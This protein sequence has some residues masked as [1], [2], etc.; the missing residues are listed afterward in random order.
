M[1]FISRRGAIAGVMVG[2]VGGVLTFIVWSSR[3]PLDPEQTLNRAIALLADRRLIEAEPLL[4][5]YLR[6][7]PDGVN[8]HLLLAQ[9][10]LEKSALTDPPDAAQSRRALGHLARIPIAAQM[11]PGEATRTETVDMARERSLASLVKLNEGKARSNLAQPA[12]AEVAWSAVLR[13]TPEVAEAG[14]LLLDLYIHQ[15]REAEA[16][17]LGLRLAEAEPDV[18]KRLE[19]LLTLAWFDA[20]QVAPQRVIRRFEPAVRR[21]PDDRHAAIALGLALVR[22]HREVEG[23][24]ILRHTVARAPDDPNALCALL[25][26]L[27]ESQQSDALMESVARI[28]AAWAVTEPFS[29]HI[30]LAALARRDW[31]AATTAL[32]RASEAE[33]HRI[34]LAYQLARALRLGGQEAEAD[35]LAVRTTRLRQSRDELLEIYRRLLGHPARELREVRDVL[36]FAGGAPAA[37]QALVAQNDP[38]PLRRF[39][40][41]CE[42]LGFPDQAR[43]WRRALTELYPWAG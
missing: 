1:R 41:L 42:D 29:E 17:R 13:L 3:A 19:W 39:A 7:Y 36:K 31:P 5:D 38:A 4:D 12:A 32:R 40:E 10:A 20:A 35:R 9:L 11:I 27:S 22:D 14:W 30:G 28:P 24:E 25:T 21:R 34:E 15:G 23:L 43:A 18:A 8:G 26:G 2:F 6:A 16:R 37:A 33:P